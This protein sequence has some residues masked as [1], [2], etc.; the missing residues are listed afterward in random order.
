MLLVV[1]AAAGRAWG[2]LRGSA[3]VIALRSCGTG[4]GRWPAGGEAMV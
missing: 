2:P 4:G 3:A 1:V